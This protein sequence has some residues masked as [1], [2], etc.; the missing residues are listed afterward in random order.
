MTP[1]WGA[2]GT[3][4]AFPH[5]CLPG[6]TGLIS[7]LSKGLSRILSST[8]IQKHQFLGTQ[9]SLWSS[10]HI[11]TWLLKKIIA[12]T[13]W[14][15]VSKV[16]FLLFNALSMFV[17]AFLPRSKCLLISW[18]SWLQSQSTVILEA[19]KIKSVPVSSIYHE[20]LGPDAM[21]FIFWMLSFK[22][23]FSLSSWLAYLKGRKISAHLN[24]H[25]RKC[26]NSIKCG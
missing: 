7:L 4:C 21:I 12:L 22:P 15:F 14:T 1:N 2:H 19:K 23:T 26:I 18:F 9:S 8:T 5:S 17:K 3:L 25:V 11:H 20:V 13:M 16:M 10:S 24:R 6:L